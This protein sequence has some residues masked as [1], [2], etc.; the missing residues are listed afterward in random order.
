MGQVSIWLR[1]KGYDESIFW[2][3]LSNLNTKSIHFYYD[4]IISD[5]IRT[6]RKGAATQLFS[7]PLGF[8]AI[9]LW[10]AIVDFWVAIK[11]KP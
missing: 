4:L 3:N 8:L 2:N 6:T 10:K 1:L 9:E 11:L 5:Y 7:R